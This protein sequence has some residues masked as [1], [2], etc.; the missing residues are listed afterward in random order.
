MPLG[1]MALLLTV[2]VAGS[3]MALA[4][5]PVP[6]M[7][8]DIPACDDGI[9]NDGDGLVD[10]LEDPS[11][12][13]DFSG[14]S[15]GGNA[16]DDGI[17]NDGDG[18][19]DWPDDP[20]CAGDSRGVSEGVPTV[21]SDRLDNDHDGV[22]DRDDPG[23]RGRAEG[24]DETD[25]QPAAS[26]IWFTSARPHGCGIRAVAVAGPDLAPARLF[27]FAK[28][29]IR[30]RGQSRRARS[31]RLARRVAPGTRASFNGLRPGRYVVSAGYPGDRFR[32]ASR[33]AARRVTLS[34]SRCRTY[35]SGTA[36]R[37]YRP[38]VVAIGASQ[39]IFN[40]RW[41]SWGRSVARGTG[42]FPANSC[43]PS[44]AAGSITLRRVT[45]R[46][47]RRRMCNG[48]LQYLTLSY[49]GSGLHGTGNFGY[50]CQ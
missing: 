7:A 3:T 15:E 50:R 49:R 14:A 41:R 18:F 22:I 43:I 45:V 37:S 16:C 47:S 26:R 38:T 1:V 28:L 42:T 17:D 44:C 36:G 29:T 2:A 13:D 9:D 33:A 6:A 10:W 23:C 30:I 11:C 46:L 27:P 25:P 35:F 21:C 34:R 4:S 5:S 40:I 20:S 32:S 8:Q 48:Y 31:M 19:E 39:R 12:A 24:R